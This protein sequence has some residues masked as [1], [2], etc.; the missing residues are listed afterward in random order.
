M[1]ILGT[2]NW[3][4]AYVTDQ[5]MIQRYVA[6]SS[7]KEARKAT[8]IYAV[9][10]IPTWILFFFI[11]TA[12]FVL[13]TL[14]PNETV[15]QLQPDEVFP[16]FII[17]YTPVGLRGLIIVGILAAGVSSLDSA[18]H[19]ST[20]VATV[21]VLRD[22]I[23]RGKRREDGFYLRSARLYNAFMLLCMIVGAI[24]FSHIPKESMFDL[25]LIAASIFGGCLPGIFLAGL[26]CPRID[27]ISC[28]TGLA[29]AIPTNIYLLLNTLNVLPKQLSIGLHSYWV[30]L[31]VNIV[32]VIVAWLTG[33]V[34]V[35]AGK[36]DPAKTIEFTVWGEHEWK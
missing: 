10:G 15:A 14:V 16:Y 20:T 29:V 13:F 5:A 7:L 27:N 11:G 28:L 19:A 6:A 17:T 3:I 36:N 12:L 22:V 31:V 34:R 18:I 9:L 8:I 25:I 32:F 35:F 33:Y 23:H 24:V 21:D 30:M 26:F 2:F 4:S 1:M